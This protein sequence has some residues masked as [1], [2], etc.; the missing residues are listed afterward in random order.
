MAGLEPTLTKEGVFY[1]NPLSIDDKQV[2]IL[3]EM[4]KK[5]HFGFRA[6]N[7]LKADHYYHS[8]IISEEIGNPKIHVIL[9]KEKPV[10]Y[11][12]NLNLALFKAHNHVFNK[13]IKGNLEGE[14][15][16]NILDTTKIGKEK[17]KQAKLKFDNQANLSEQ[18][19]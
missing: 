18:K 14:I 4:S 12:G 6:Y 7:K 10:D 17:F 19:E 15:K 8:A 2:I 1:K 13:I 11:A 9:D 3:E 5:E 16:S